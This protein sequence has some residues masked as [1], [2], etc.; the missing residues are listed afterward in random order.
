MAQVRNAASTA[1]G[2]DP[3]QEILNIVAVVVVTF[4][5]PRATPVM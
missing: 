3:A 5:H 4:A 1:S 2:W